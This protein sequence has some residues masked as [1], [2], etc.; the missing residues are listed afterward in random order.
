[1][2]QL[3]VLH[4]ELFSD[5]ITMQGYILA[6][7]AQFCL[8]EGSCEVR[9]RSA[10]QREMMPPVLVTHAHSRLPNRL[11]I[12]V[13]FHSNEYSYEMVESQSERLIA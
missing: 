2:V 12:G 6:S 9:H 1:M 11:C 7:V 8:L 3:E 10:S 13:A 5:L 4:I